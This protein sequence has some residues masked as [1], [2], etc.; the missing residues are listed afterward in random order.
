MLRVISL[1]SLILNHTSIAR[2]E[3][4][5]VQNPD[6]S[7]S[8]ETLRKKAL[9]D[10][11]VLELLGVTSN[12][13]DEAITQNPRCDLNICI[14]VAAS[15]SIPP[16]SLKQNM[17]DARQFGIPIVF[18]GFVNNSML[19]TQAA[20][21]DIFGTLEEAEGFS[22]D[23]TFFTRF[24]IQAVPTMVGI[25]RELQQCETAGCRLD[26][27]SAHAGSLIIFRCASR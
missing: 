9:S 19:E 1:L 7:N 27:A 14:F 16:L 15:F 8:F 17:R 24:D 6:F 2:S 12:R 18:R 21:K 11:K 5:I 4:A 26:E 20:L 3:Q 13:N 22:I 23:P 10:P 25:N